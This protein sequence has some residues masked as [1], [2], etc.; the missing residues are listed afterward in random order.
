MTL[1]RCASRTVL[2]GKL[3]LSSSFSCEKAT[4]SDVRRT[5]QKQ[6]EDFLE[7]CRV[8]EQQHRS[9]VAAWGSRIRGE[10]SKRMQWWSMLENDLWNG[11]VVVISIACQYSNHDVCTHHGSLQL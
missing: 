2:A 1:T 7:V 10:V 9:E 4:Q 11:L 5:E 6:A 8:M 3:E